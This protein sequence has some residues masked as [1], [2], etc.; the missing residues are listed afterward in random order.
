[1]NAQELERLIRRDPCMT[2]VTWGVFARD[3][4]PRHGLLPGA[5]VVNSHEAPGEHWF[6]LYVGE[7]FELYDSLGK[8]PMN[9][10][11]ESPCI[12]I[13]KRLQT[14][15]SVSCGKY[16]L[17]F[18]Y[19]RSRGIQMHAILHSLKNN[20]EQVVKDHYRWLHTV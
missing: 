3:E 14:I 8:M 13:D 5:Y 12:Y 10:G 18:L 1:M 6:L 15:N 9:Y 20:S 2:A 19:W 17:Y 7:Q 16:V 4:I 11:I